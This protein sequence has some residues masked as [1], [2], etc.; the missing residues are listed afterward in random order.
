[1]VERG[2]SKALGGVAKLVSKKS[3][4]L[5]ARVGEKF[6]G[7]IVKEEAAP[8]VQKFTQLFKELVIPAREGFEKALPKDL[9]ELQEKAVSKIADGVRAGKISSLEAPKLQKE[10]LAKIEGVKKNFAIGKRVVN[11]GDVLKAT[12]PLTFTNDEVKSLMDGVYKYA[13]YDLEGLDT[14]EAVQN[15]LLTGELPMPYQIRN[16]AKVYGDDFAEAVSKLSTKPK[17]VLAKTWDA[18]NIPRATLSSMDVSATFRQGLILGLT[19]PTEI[20]K[21]FFRQMKAFASEKLA[22]DMDHVIKSDPLYNEFRKVGGYLAPI[23]KAATA[24]KMEESFASKLAEKLPFVRRSERGFITYLNELRF[25]AYK[26]AR[27]SWVAQG[28]TDTELK[29]LANFINNASGRGELPAKL[30]TYAP[31]LNSFFFSPRLQMSRMELPII[32]GKMLFSDKPYMR[33]EGAKALVT[34]L[35]GG[36]AVLAVAKAA[37]AEVELDPRSSDFAKI[38]VGD[39]R[40]DIWTGYAQYARFAAQ[41]A[42]GEKKQAY[43]NISKES[44]LSIAARFLQSKTSPAT[45][46]L[47]DLLTGEKYSGEPIAKD[48]Q[49]FI[50]TAKEKMMPL[51][52]QD[53][54]DAM[55][56]GGINPLS[57]TTT[58]AAS[59][60]IGTLTYV[61][62]LVKLKNDIAHQKG[63]SSWSQIDPITQKEL[64][65]LPQ[66][67]QAAIEYDRQMM[68]TT[69]GNWRTFGNAVEDTFTQ[70]VTQATEK[71]R[72][73]GDG[74]TYRKDI[75]TAFAERR[76]GYE[77]RSND[78]QFA[79]I[80]ERFNSKSDAELLV[81]LGPEQ[82]AI[83]VYEDAL[84]GDDMYDEFGDYR[85]DEADIR[86]QQLIQSL[87][88]DLY[89]YVV[90]YKNLKYEDLPAEFQEYRKAQ[91]VLSEYWN[92]AD[93]AVKL[94]GERDTPAKERWIARR[95]KIL[96][97]R[98]KQVK[99]YLDL[100]YSK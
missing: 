44:R 54:I 6:V 73:T 41:L 67:Q 17:D 22:L 19:H 57:I 33:K 23:G 34:F 46:L 43:G 32:L 21:A 12:E 50:D 74:V 52:L 82:M 89:N 100:F 84:E 62:K 49:G 83:K 39:T 91:Q 31:M 98:N 85:F 30:E 42:T 48:T 3:E 20:P 70:N 35:G 10:A 72:E 66:L 68:G 15:L 7:K 78:E 93:D 64:E 13:E 51:V 92:I 88:E 9:R 47:V 14:A 71:Y 16:M 65:K 81:K 61:N 55:E 29:T 36:A 53:M 63:Y 56:Q 45:G 69:W 77:A 76:G 94:F 99:Y 96:K 86:K 97:M 60:G 1:L 37:G 90:E 38:K 80:V 8:E 58:A 75:Q 5:G 27:N 18:M 25:S 59:L 40:F 87:G 2:T 24:S 4:A 28:A 95:R 26:Q 79:E 11:D